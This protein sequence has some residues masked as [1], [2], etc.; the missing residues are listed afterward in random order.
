MDGSSALIITP[1][2]ADYDFRALDDS[3]YHASEKLNSNQREFYT[4]MI[5]DAKYVKSQ[6]RNSEQRGVISLENFE[7]EFAERLSEAQNYMSEMQFTIALII[8][9]LDALVEDREE[10]MDF[11]DML[12]KLHTEIKESPES[13]K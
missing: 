1:G 7:S 9:R 13:K 10:K 3:F 5:A 8:S 4:R 6:K 2:F 12:N 11:E